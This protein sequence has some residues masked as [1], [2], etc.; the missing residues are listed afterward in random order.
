MKAIVH[1]KYGPPDELQLKEVDKPVPKDN[2]ILIKIHATS[3]TTGDCNARNFTFAPKLFRNMAKMYFGYKKPRINI[4]GTEMAGEV[5]S[6]GKEVKLFKV[7]DQVFGTP[8]TTYGTHAEYICMK[9]NGAVALKPPNMSHEEA[10]V[11]P[12]AGLTTLF[13][14]RDKGKVHQKP[15]SPANK[16]KVLIIGASGSIGTY[17]VQLAKYYEAEVTGV[18]S[19]KNLELVKSIG[20]DQVIDYT[21]KDYTK[22][23]ETF[24]V[25][26]DVVGKSSF[27]RCKNLLKP[28]GI[29]LVTLI[30]RAEFVQILGTSITGGKQ[31][32]GGMAPQKLKDLIF[33][34]ELGEKD[35]IKPV[36]DRR[37]PLE[38]TIEAFK[39]VEEGHKKGNVVISLV[40]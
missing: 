17:S 15:A 32:K 18:C 33:L 35:K 29:Y 5:E 34:K 14:I 8:G 22:S 27:K 24:D 39:Y 12:F 30:E 19:T 23:D 4:L 3:V 1:T 10:A 9:E 16:K 13:Y 6:I 26:F 37:Y 20:A 28:K 21:K 36:I 40:T 25:I 31:V 2:E 38:K 11:I 7:G